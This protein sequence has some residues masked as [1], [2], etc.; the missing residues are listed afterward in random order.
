MHSKHGQWYEG[1][2]DWGGGLVC[3]YQGWKK[4]YFYYKDI[5]RHRGHKP[6][7]CSR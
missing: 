1:I 4:S 5:M 2:A 6:V 7:A 3:L